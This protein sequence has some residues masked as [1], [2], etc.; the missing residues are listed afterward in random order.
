[1]ALLNN[2]SDQN[3]DELATKTFDDIE[4]YLS[5]ANN[6]DTKDVNSG[7]AILLKHNKNHEI[8]QEK[9]SEDI[10]ETFYSEIKNNKDT[11]LY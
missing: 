6:L 1:M 7:I 5:A 2:A 9:D 4:Q 8:H 11:R 3:Q 10:A